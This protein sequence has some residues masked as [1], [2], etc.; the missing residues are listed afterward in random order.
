VHGR[1]LFEVAG[2]FETV[3]ISA[4]GVKTLRRNFHL[5]LIPRSERAEEACNLAA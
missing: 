2:E 3:R 4:E 5:L 1:V